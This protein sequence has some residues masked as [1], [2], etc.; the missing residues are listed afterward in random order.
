MKLQCVSTTASP[1]GCA[2]SEAVPRDLLSLHCH[3]GPMEA[4]KI[5]TLV[6]E[7]SAIGEDAEADV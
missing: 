3:A 7:V 5:I 1:R 4:I 2:R 6:C